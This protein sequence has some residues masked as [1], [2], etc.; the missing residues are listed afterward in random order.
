MKNIML[1]MKYAKENGTVRPLE[2]FLITKD[3]KEIPVALSGTVA[4]N[5][6]YEPIGFIGV[7]KDITERKMAEHELSRAV[8]LLQNVINTSKDLIFV[9]DAQLR[10][11]LCNN[12]FAQA[13]GKKPEEL[14]GRTDIENGWSHDIV[15][16]NPEKGI[17]GFEADDL[18]ALAGKTVYNPSD[19]A[20]VEGEIRIFDTKKNAVASRRR[21]DYRCFGHFPR[22][23][24]PEACRGGVGQVGGQAPYAL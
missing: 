16:G 7:C 21:Q 22:H 17:R 5:S 14:Y 4:L 10:T 2:T 12:V 13:L 20:N 3:G 18:E 1:E 6:K 8:S 19:P 24:R 11:I 23:H 9:K 15:L